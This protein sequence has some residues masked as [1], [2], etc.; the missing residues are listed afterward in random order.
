MK[1]ILLSVLTAC[2]V[3]S[4][5]SALVQY[6]VSLSGP[7]ESPANASPGIGF[8]TVI[9]DNASH[10]L[11]LQ[12]TFSGLIAT[13]T[14]TM[15]S[16]IH[17]ATA[18]PGV[19]TAGVATQTPSFVGF[20]LG[21]TSGSFA[22]TLDLT[23]ASSWNP[24]FITAHNNSIAD[25]ETALAN[26]MAGGQAYWNIHSGAIP[27]GEIRGFLVPIPEPSTYLAGALLFIPFGVHGIRY[28]RSRKQVA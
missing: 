13:N 7:N 1:K 14:G 15:A 3:W 16:H 2:G 5:Q 25:S 19:G 28:L 11:Q 24:A 12:V 9:Y 22:N 6:G 27:G 20:P 10:L 17:A 26:A 8:G 4:A 21:V 23:L 18:V